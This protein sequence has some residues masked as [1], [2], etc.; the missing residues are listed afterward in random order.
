[1]QSAGFRFDLPVGS[2][3]ETSDGGRRWASE[4]KRKTSLEG[5]AQGDVTL[6]LVRRNRLSLALFFGEGVLATPSTEIKERSVSLPPRGALVPRFTQQ[7]L[8]ASS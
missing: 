4:R 1:M 5:E 3:S 6:A 7:S 2:T 8:G